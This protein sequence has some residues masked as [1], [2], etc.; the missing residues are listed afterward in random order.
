MLPQA[1]SDYPKITEL[2]ATG[3][4]PTEE[5]DFHQK[6]EVCE[7]KKLLATDYH[8]LIGDV[9][10]MVFTYLQEPDKSLQQYTDEWMSKT[11]GYGKPPE[12]MCPIVNK[13]GNP[14]EGPYV[15]ITS[16][17]EGADM[18]KTKFEVSVEVY[19]EHRVVK[20]EFYWDD[21]LVTTINSA[22]YKTTYSVSKDVSGD[23]TIKVV[24]YDGKGDDNSYSVEVS[25][26][27]ADPTPTPTP[28]DDEGSPLP[29]PTSISLFP[30][31]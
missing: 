6:V 2:F 29:T 21:T 27:D 4:V 24:A 31:L 1:G 14:L 17:K 30:E 7:S 10:E 13:D 11:E 12:E 3:T 28:E 9:I 16:P 26:P 22:P 25:F 15:E 5:D 8:R 23:H 20:V 18:E 19:S